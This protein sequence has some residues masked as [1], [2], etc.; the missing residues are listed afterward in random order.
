MLQTKFTALVIGFLCVGTL[1]AQPTPQVAKRDANQVQAL[2]VSN[3]A[4][5]DQLMAT[6]AGVGNNA[7]MTQEQQNLKPYMMPVRKMGFRGM[8]W[9]YMLA[10]CLEYYVNIS[11][12]FKDNLSPDYI[13]LSL[14]SQGQRTS[15][16]EGLRFLVQY[17]TVSAAIVPYDAAQISATVYATNKFQINNFLHLFQP[18]AST[19]EKIFEIRKA[20]MRGNPVL[21]ELQA[22][23]AFPALTQ[24]LRWE[25]VSTSTPKAYALLIIGYDENEQAFEVMSSWGSTWGNNGYL[26]M[27]YNDLANAAVNGY[28]M[29][30]NTY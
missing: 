6:V 25:P 3:T 28:V 20:L 13:S 4:L 1:L 22:N 2:G 15:L 8:D 7:R 5:F 21:I 23:D 17:G 16:E 11:R 26:W 29:V 27:D 9:S 30:P 18:F 12:N 24:T 10:S 14:Q 19:R